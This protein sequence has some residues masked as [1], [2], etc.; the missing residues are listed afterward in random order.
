MCGLS[1]SWVK[2]DKQDCICFSP[3]SVHSPKGTYSEWK[4]FVPTV[5]KCF[6]LRVSLIKRETN[7]SELSP[8]EIYTHTSSLLLLFIVFQ[9]DV[10]EGGLVPKSL[11][12]EEYT[13]RS[14]DE[15]PLHIGESLYMTSHVVKDYPHEVTVYCIL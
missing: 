14:P 5:I 10:P 7:F 11:Y 2:G 6:P 13:D 9:C 1:N 4:E 12:R 15:P 3:E 8:M